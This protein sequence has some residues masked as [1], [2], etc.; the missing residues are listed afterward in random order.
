MMPVMNVSVMMV[1]VMMPVMMS[2]MV[3]VMMSVIDHF[4][5]MPVFDV[6]SVVDVRGG[7]GVCG[8]VGLEVVRLV[9]VIF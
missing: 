9:I 3:A 8:V 5:V 1:S 7:S 2:V 4:V 6:M